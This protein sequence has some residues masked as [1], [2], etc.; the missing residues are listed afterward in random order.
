MRPQRLLQSFQVGPLLTGTHTF[1]CIFRL[2]MRTHNMTWFVW[3]TLNPSSLSSPPA[4]ASLCVSEY[5][6]SGHRNVKLLCHGFTC[7]TDSDAPRPEPCT[8][9]PSLFP[10]VC[11]LIFVA[12]GLV[13]LPLLSTL[14]SL[15]L[16]LTP[17]LC[18]I[19]SCSLLSPLLPVKFHFTD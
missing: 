17:P 9:C 12:Q 10:Y 2:S 19:C 18:L 4:L 8:V 5:L 7:S 1:F 13:A 6:L 3:S 14:F 11:L 15:S 16:S